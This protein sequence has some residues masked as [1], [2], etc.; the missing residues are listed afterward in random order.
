M[1]NSENSENTDNKIIIGIQKITKI[2]QKI[3]EEIMPVMIN[4]TA[5]LV[6]LACLVK[7]ILKL[8][9]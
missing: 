3:N 2:L 5:R 7:L 9:K 6:L 1:K 4:A 8:I